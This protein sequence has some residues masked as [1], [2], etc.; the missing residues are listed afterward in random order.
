M[1]GAMDTTVLRIYND[2]TTF[3]HNMAKP[4]ESSSNASCASFI[5]QFVI[6]QGPSQEPSSYQHSFNTVLAAKLQ[7]NS[8]IVVPRMYVRCN[9]LPAEELGQQKL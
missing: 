8:T 4:S 5:L 9:V 1:A 7:Q 6:P 2:F 3:M